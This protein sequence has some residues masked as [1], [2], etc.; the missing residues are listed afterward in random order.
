[1]NSSS[2]VI[3]TSLVLKRAGQSP[4]DSL[5]KP[6]ENRA[7]FAKHGRWPYFQLAIIAL[8]SVG[9]NTPPRADPE[10]EI[11]HQLQKPQSVLSRAR[12]TPSL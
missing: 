8:S 1:M 2:S 6:I 7:T 4:E 9:V 5:L 3:H 10:L 11:G 12:E